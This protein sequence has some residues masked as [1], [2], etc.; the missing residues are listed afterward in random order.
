MFCTEGTWRRNMATCLQVDPLWYVNVTNYHIH[1]FIFFPSEGG[2]APWRGD[3][4]T[5][6]VTPANNLEL[7]T[8]AQLVSLSLECGRTPEYADTRRTR[9]LLLQAKP[10][11]NGTRSHNL[12]ALITPAVQHFWPTDTHT[13][14]QHVHICSLHANRSLQMSQNR[15]F[16]ADLKCSKTFF[17]LTCAAPS[18]ELSK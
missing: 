16:K 12:L 9:R 4:Q 2:V 13:W 15:F 1:S 3:K 6:I 5:S 14:G 7:T 8:L 18:K 10:P 11:G 17:F